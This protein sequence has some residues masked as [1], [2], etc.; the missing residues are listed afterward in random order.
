MA[1]EESKGFYAENTVEVEING[2]KCLVNKHEA[3]A[4]KKKLAAKK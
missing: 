2:V 3:E 4:L 1:K